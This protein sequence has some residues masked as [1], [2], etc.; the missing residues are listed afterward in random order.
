MAAAIFSAAPSP[1]TGTGHSRIGRANRR[2]TVVWMSCSTAPWAEVTT[3]IT[4]GRKGSWRLRS[5]NPSAASLIRNASI[6]ASI[7]PAPAYSSRSM[8]NWYWLLSPPGGHAAGGDHLD[9][10]FRLQPHIA[11]RRLPDDAAD[12]AA[13]VLQAE[14]GV[15]GAVA[16]H[17]HQLATHPHPAERAP[18]ACASP[19][20]R[21]R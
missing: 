13:L 7:A 18:P 2:A 8:I 4:P 6:R 5:N 21:S 12:R 9:P 10:V 16:L 19:R 15:A 20:R 17:L 14:I 1:C 11:R 3:P